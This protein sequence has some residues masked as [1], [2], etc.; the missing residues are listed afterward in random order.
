[1]VQLALDVR[2]T[3]RFGSCW[4]CSASGEAF[5][6]STEFWIISFLLVLVLPKN[7]LISYNYGVAYGVLV[8]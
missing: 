5:A 7:I 3:G 2:I 4:P 6:L 8:V 1:M